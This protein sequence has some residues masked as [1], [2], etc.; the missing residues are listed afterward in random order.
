MAEFGVARPGPASH[1]G[2]AFQRGTNQSGMRNLNERLVL[3]LVRQRGNL[4][5]AEISQMTELSAQTVSVIVRALE[6][7]GLL[8]RNEPVRGR[9]GQPSVPMSLD[10]A[11]ARAAATGITRLEPAGDD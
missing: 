8:M 11:L 9:V 5:K 3:S 1:L 7:D 6:N 2:R 10:P 4:S